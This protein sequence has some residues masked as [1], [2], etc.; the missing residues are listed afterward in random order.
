M[1]LTPFLTIFQLYRGSRFYYWRKPGY[2][3]KTTNVVSSIL[4]KFA[5]SGIRTHNISGD[6]H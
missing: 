6:R 5:M 1:G 3:E 2:P 4:R